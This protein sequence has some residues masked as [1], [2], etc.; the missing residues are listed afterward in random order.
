MQFEYKLITH[1]SI[2][3]LVESNQ[4]FNLLFKSLSFEDLSFDVLIS[5][6]KNLQ[7]FKTKYETK[8]NL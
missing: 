3:L 4:I 1:D 5:S 8:P 2:N 7:T 6:D